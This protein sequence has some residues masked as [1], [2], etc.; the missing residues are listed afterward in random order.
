MP[1]NSVSRLTSL[2]GD[3]MSGINSVTTKKNPYSHVS[4]KKDNQTIITEIIQPISPA[5]GA[6]LSELPLPY[7]NES[8]LKKH[9]TELSTLLGELADLSD[10]LEDTLGHLQEESDFYD[11]MRQFVSLFNATL[12]L[13]QEYDQLSKTNSSDYVC[14]QLRNAQYE[15]STY[16]FELEPSDNLSIL[17]SKLKSKAPQ[18]ILNAFFDKDK[19]FHG[20][21]F[22]FHQVLDGKAMHKVPLQVKIQG[23]II[24]QLG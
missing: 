24:D 16:G 22:Y 8:A 18:A 23:I 10:T 13:L 19:L 2:R 6:N 21:I 15:L 14:L 11:K 17:W 20:L 12:V 4:M 9:R 1:I 5:K 7:Y 3:D